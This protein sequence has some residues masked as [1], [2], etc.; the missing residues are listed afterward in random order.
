MDPNARELERL[1]FCSGRIFLSKTRLGPEKPTV[2]RISLGKDA[3]HQPITPIQF[4]LLKQFNRP[5]WQCHW[6][7]LHIIIIWTSRFN[8]K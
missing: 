2:Q 8:G 7:I 1:T 4:H 3:L 5:S 6:Q